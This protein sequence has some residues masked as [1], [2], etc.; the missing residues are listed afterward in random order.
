MAFWKKSDDPWDMEPKR[1]VPPS[2]SG[3]EEQESLLDS[4]RGWAAQKQAAE[5]E[6][7]KRPAET[8]PWCGRDMEQGFLSGSRGVFWT[9]GVPSAKVLWLGAGRENTLRV[10][11]EG[12]L[13]TYKSTWYCPSCEKMVFDAAGLKPLRESTPPAG[14]PYT[15]VF[16]ETP[17]DGDQP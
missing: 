12:S 17:S 16:G 15:G 3:Q 9:R 10:D 4:V 2:S 13:A 14:S 8:C 5:A 11:D 6:R 1:P 7:L